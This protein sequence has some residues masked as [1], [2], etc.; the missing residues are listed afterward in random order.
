MTGLLQHLFNPRSIVLVGASDKSAWSQLIHGN[1]QDS[2][3]DGEIMVV[4]K[5]GVPAHGIEGHANCRALP[6]IPDLAYVFVPGESALEALQDVAEA[7]IANA[8]L[9]SSGFAETGQDGAAMQR[10]IGEF[11]R[12]Q[13]LNLLGP[14]SLGFNNYAGRVA[15]SAF[16]VDLK[17]RPG[18]LAVI[19][20]SG[21]TAH[22]IGQFARMQ[23][24][25]L[26]C[27]V[28]TGNEE[29]LGLVD[30]LAHF[31]EDPGTRAIA[32]FAESIKD[33][34]A[35]RTV[36]ARASAVGKP[37][38]VLKVGK[39]ELASQLAQAHTGSVTGDD[40]TFD[41]VCRHYG[42]IRVD[43][44]ET[45]VIAAGLLDQVGAIDG[46]I[47]IISI[48]GG[49]CEIIADRAVT[50]GLDLAPFS[51]QT[52]ERLHAVI[53][54]FGSVFNPL[55]VTGAAVRDP[56][57][58]ERI[59]DILSDDPAIGLV[60]AVQ[61]VP[62]AEGDTCNEPILSAIGRGLTA[63]RV[64]GVLINQA[65]QPV[66]DHT[67]AVMAKCSIPRV[68]GGVDHAMAAF[69][70]LQQ[71]SRRPRHDGASRT[72]APSSARPASERQ[73]LEWL[74]TRGVP[75]MPH[76]LVANADE[77]VVAWMAFGQPVVLKIASPDI[78]HKSDIGGVRLNLD[79]DDAIRA[80]YDD[81]MAAAR[82]HHPDARIEGCIVAPMRS[83]GVELFVG[84]ARTPWGPVIA[85]G[86]GGIWIEV[87]KDTSLR[88]LPVSPDEARAMLGE[89]KGT[90]LLE[91]Y[92]GSPA[93][94]LDAVARAISTIGDAALS[95][96]QDLVSLEINPLRVL[97]AEVEALDALAVWDRAQADHDT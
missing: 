82:R 69:A 8:V 81:V 77:A 14:N 95:L 15:V 43:S 61:D 57:L 58:F 36:A 94:D 22:V 47:G 49:A 91:G 45:M 62:S 75:V 74:E 3:F 79:G 55:D 73:A 28:A 6:R 80:A 64:P 27:V 1:L 48:S 59:L 96:G 65:L 76:R 44:L 92:R 24:I 41:A 83:G 72:I 12:S 60:A 21:A 66:S 19:S 56:S 13:G 23:G 54:D 42:V 29:V 17:A 25:G 18:G 86:L 68:V 71:W 84:T 9:L 88:L 30:V 31:V 34:M 85:A 5:R 33:P 70:A 26:S 51:A 35:F 7:G 87:L 32:I 40:V 90:K 4:N 46:E 2:G 50:A 97:G 39:S 10:R 20:Q 93:C 52:Q 89:L 16:P 53:P 11:A 37:I 38:V 78:L 63:A 67:Q